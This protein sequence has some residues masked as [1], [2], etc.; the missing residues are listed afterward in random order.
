M[1]ELDRIVAEESRKRNP[2]GP[3]PRTFSEI[4]RMVG[5]MDRMMKQK[6]HDLLDG[7]A[8]TASAAEEAKKALYARHDAACI[9][10]AKHDRAGLSAR[11]RYPVRYTATV[12]YS[13]SA[14]TAEAICY[15][16]S[17]RTL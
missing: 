11:R 6:S 7:R 8:V 15:V 5:R 13:S 1:A 14:R 4:L 12:S 17:A 10:E 16:T 2:D 9:G 3:P